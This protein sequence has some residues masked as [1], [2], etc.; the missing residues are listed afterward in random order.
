MHG[1]RFGVIFVLSVCLAIISSGVAT[2]KPINPIDY[3]APGQIGATP[4]TVT[5]EWLY[6]YDSGSSS[7]R[8][9]TVTLTGWVDETGE[10]RDYSADEATPFLQCDVGRRS[11]TITG[12]RAGECFSFWMNKEITPSVLKTGIL[13]PVGGNYAWYLKLAKGTYSTYKSWLTLVVLDRTQAPVYYTHQAAGILDIFDDPDFYG[14]VVCYADFVSGVGLI[15]HHKPDYS[16]TDN[17]TWDSYILESVTFPGVPS[18][19]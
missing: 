16:D 9:F 1:K 12:A 7:G 17:I 13:I 8:E 18:R 10:H 15:E 5:G 2:A 6:R 11:M 3:F 14:R 19:R 4:E